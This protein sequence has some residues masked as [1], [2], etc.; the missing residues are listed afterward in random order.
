[1][2]S[3]LACR[4]IPPVTTKLPHPTITGTPAAGFSHLASVTLDLQKTMVVAV[5]CEAFARHISQSTGEGLPITFVLNS[6]SGTLRRGTI[7]LG[8]NNCEQ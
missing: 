4:N 5:G 8:P 6:D 2:S 7:A 1:M 3:A